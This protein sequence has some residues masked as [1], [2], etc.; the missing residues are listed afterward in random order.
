MKFLNNDRK[1]FDHCYICGS[2]NTSTL[3]PNKS[4]IECQNCKFAYFEHLPSKQDLDNIYANYSRDSYI[5]DSSHQKILQN[6][7][8]IL[9]KRDFQSVLDIACGECYHL[10]ALKELNPNLELYASE[11]ISAKSNVISKGYKF[12]DGE[13]Y[14]QT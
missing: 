5:T 8:E 10:D 4:I 2:S 6:M 13:F 14:P 3:Y 1:S 11:H 7:N 12:L 9:T